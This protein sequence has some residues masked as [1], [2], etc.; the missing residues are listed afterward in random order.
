MSTERLDITQV[1]VTLLS[2]VVLFFLYQ[3]T[4]GNASQY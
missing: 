3:Y 2:I 4:L 1:M